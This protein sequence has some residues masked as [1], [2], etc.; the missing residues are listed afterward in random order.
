MIP[1]V[2]QNH[3]NRSMAHLRRKLARRLAHIG[4]IYS[5]VGPSGKPGGV[6]FAVHLQRELDSQMR[7]THGRRE[8]LESKLIDIRRRVSKLDTSKNA[9]L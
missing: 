9:G 3:P 2:I 5:R 6:Q 7:A 8:A 1:L 4:S